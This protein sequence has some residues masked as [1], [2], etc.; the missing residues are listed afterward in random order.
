M[1]QSQQEAHRLTIE[2]ST[3]HV[4]VRRDGVELAESEAAVVLREGKLPPRY[5][6]P[7]EDVRMDLLIGNDTTSHCPFKGDARYWS[8]PDVA[9]IAW[10]YE[11]PIEGAEK[12]A[13]LVCFYNEKVD[14]VLDGEV[15][16]RPT[17]RW[18]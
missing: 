4:V 3:A 15:L 8:L 17:T 16:E 5:Y 7:R 18:S 12:I 14:I 10:S 13:G 11:S 6:L 9:D 1:S 2:P